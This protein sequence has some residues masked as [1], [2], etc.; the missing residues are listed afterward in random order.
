M[1]TWL[2]VRNDDMYYLTWG[3]PD[4][5]REY[6]NG[7]LALGEI[8][9]GFYMGCDGYNPTRTF[10][11]KNSVTQGMLEVERQEYMMKIWGR[12]SYNPNTPN[13]V[14]KKYIA[15]KYPTVTTD[16]LFNAWRSSSKGIQLA[17]ELIQGTYSLD[18]HWYPENCGSGRGPGFRT[19]ANF[20]G[21]NIASGSKLCPIKKSAVDSCGTSMSSYQVADLI[22]KSS[23]EALALIAEMSASQNTELGVT[24]NNIR[25][26]SYLGLYYAEKIRGATYLK[27]NNS[28]SAKE[29]MGRAYCKWMDYVNLMDS[30]FTGMDNQRVDN[31]ANWHVYNANVLKEY[32][33]LGGIGTPDCK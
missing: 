33:D 30:M 22:E 25:A 26:L 29:A 21:A 9:E 4:F 3:N 23:N 27:A 2:T 14:F 18:F 13:E 8:F 17:T 10:F 28:S 15:V 19:I 6:V 11:S 12:L 7:M 1:K 31:F 5:A 32:T 16:K 20:A 24:L